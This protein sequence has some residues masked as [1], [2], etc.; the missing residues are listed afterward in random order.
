MLKSMYGP[1]VTLYGDPRSAIGRQNL[2]PG[3]GVWGPKP[4]PAPRGFAHPLQ[5][6]FSGMSDMSSMSA[7]G[8]RDGSAEKLGGFGGVTGSPA[9]GGS[10]FWSAMM[11]TPGFG[12][13]SSQNPGAGFSFMGSP[14]NGSSPPMGGG[15]MTQLPGSGNSM[16]GVMDMAIRQGADGVMRDAL[17]RPIDQGGGFAPQG[18]LQNPVGRA[19]SLGGM[20]GRRQGY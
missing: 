15:T 6:D 13:G 9:G 20:F 12:G 5:N 17:G 16:G 3:A 11:N 4:A 2:G 8:S 10:D 18:G 1:G 19:S 7:M 14:V